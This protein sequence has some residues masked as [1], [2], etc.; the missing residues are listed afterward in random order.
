MGKLLKKIN[1]E[2]IG[3]LISVVVSVISVTI[4]IFT[5]RAQVHAADV[6]EEKTRQVI[7]NSTKLADYDLVLLIGKVGNSETSDMTPEN[8][9]YQVDS[10]KR[11]L[12]VIE[13]VQ[14]TELP[15]NESM[16]YQMYR[17][18]L[19]DIIYRINSSVKNIEKIS[20]KKKNG[21]LIISDQNRSIFLHELVELKSVIKE[22]QKIIKTNKNLYDQK[23]YGKFV[24]AFDDHNQEW[25][26][27]IQED[28]SDKVG[29]ILNGGN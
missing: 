22:D 15:K 16:N 1:F 26:N 5:W 25:M 19:S 14:I 11:N 13:D 9:A 28:N 18:D 4:S 12:T 21:A 10:L 27:Q 3:V 29:R 6:Y 20:D 17:Q 7:V 23:G 2:N 8:I 24:K